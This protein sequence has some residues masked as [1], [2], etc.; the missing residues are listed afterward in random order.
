MPDERMPGYK[1][2]RKFDRLADHATSVLMGQEDAMLLARN[3]IES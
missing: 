2:I 3:L 1:G